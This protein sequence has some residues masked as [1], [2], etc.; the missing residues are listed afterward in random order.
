MCLKCGREFENSLSSYVHI[1]RAHGLNAIQYRQMFGLLNKCK[2]CGKDIP[3]SLIRLFC[4]KSCCSKARSIEKRK[5]ITEHPENYYY[6]KIGHKKSAPCEKLKELLTEKGISFIEEWKPLSN[7]GFS[8]DIAFPDIK[9][10][11][12]VNG[13]QHYDSN[14]SL[15]PYYQERHDLIELAGWKLIEM[16]YSTCYILKDIE[17]II[18]FRV[19]PDYSEY[20]LIQSN[21]LKEKELRRP[22]V[23]GQKKTLKYE[24]SQ[25]S[26]IEKIRSS[27]IVFSKYG[28]SSD[29]SREISL[30]VQ[31]VARWMRRFLPDI[32]SKA[33]HRKTHDEVIRQRK[34]HPILPFG[35]A[36]LVAFKDVQENR[37]KLV[38]GSSIDFSK[39]G[40][41]ARVSELLGLKKSTTIE[42]LRR[43]VPDL[44]QK[45]L[46]NK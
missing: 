21:R 16:H 31:R 34:E 15:K 23:P 39:V 40:C 7:R 4:S 24:E 22:L 38:R 37:V 32:Y 8:I 43:Y 35:V 20:F 3:D 41:V 25:R 5:W 36:R 33:C 6:N 13:S 18:S 28:W 44:Y 14:G 2:Q 29:V 19:Q 30:P 10:G 26:N 1:K 17:S 45:H 46:D 9:L 12:E 42:W 27:G 11:I